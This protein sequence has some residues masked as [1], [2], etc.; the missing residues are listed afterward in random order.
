MSVLDMRSVSKTYGTGDA[1]V[2]ALLDV[3]LSVEAGAMV[4]GPAAP[5]NPPC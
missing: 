3:D 1:T 2:H 5:G 4:A